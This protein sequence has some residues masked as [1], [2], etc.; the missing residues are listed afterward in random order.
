VQ[1]P[2][3][4]RATST[5]EV[6][7]SVDVSKKKIDIVVVVILYVSNVAQNRMYLYNSGAYAFFIIRLVFF[8][9]ILICTAVPESR[10]A[11]PGD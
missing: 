1:D 6:H 7:T 10:R 2:E 3:H 5:T 9:F 8:V 4:V 11:D